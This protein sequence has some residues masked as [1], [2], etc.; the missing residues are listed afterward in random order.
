L[1]TTASEETYD[2]DTARQLI[3][4]MAVICEEFAQSNAEIPNLDTLRDELN[5]I[6]YEVFELSPQEEQRV[7]QRYPIVLEKRTKYKPERFQQLMARFR[8]QLGQ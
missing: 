1:V 6:R 7:E 2:F 4:A 5:R 3:G 8:E